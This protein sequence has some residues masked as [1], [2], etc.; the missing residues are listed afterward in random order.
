M[1]HGLVLAIV[2]LLIAGSF[3]ASGEVS[4]IEFDNISGGT[5]MYTADMVDSLLGEH[6]TKSVEKAVEVSTNHMN[7]VVELYVPK[8][9][10]QWK[11]DKEQPE[12][13]DLATDMGSFSWN[14][15]GFWSNEGDVHGESHDSLIINHST[16][17]IELIGSTPPG[18]KIW[19]YF[20]VNDPSSGSR[21]YLG[22]ELEKGGGVKYDETFTNNV[23]GMG[24]HRMPVTKET[25]WSIESVSDPRVGN[26]YVKWITEDDSEYEWY[27]QTGWMVQGDY[28]MSMPGIDS[29]DPLATRIDFYNAIE[30]PDTEEGTPWIS[31]HGTFVRKGLAA[32]GILFSTEGFTNAVKGVV[33]IGN[34]QALPLKCVAGGYN[35]QGTS[36]YWYCG[37]FKECSVTLGLVDGSTINAE[38]DKVYSGVVWMEI[39]TQYVLKEEQSHEISVTHDGRNYYFKGSY[40]TG[41]YKNKR[42]YLTESF[43]VQALNCEDR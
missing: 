34:L 23:V 8:N 21:L 14:F 3:S 43:A 5:H 11:K 40:V 20:S 6:D 2:G 25:P 9:Y 22:D 27:H 1:I 17:G 18:G 19:N 42:H 13:P 30:N 24:T 4:P 15:Y 26:V 36:F 38:K 10:D 29:T 33:G 32:P 41:H 12:N 7:E 31:V 37:S 35:V 28:L 39:H 16:N